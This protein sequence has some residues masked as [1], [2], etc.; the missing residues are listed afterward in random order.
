MSVPL[1]AAVDVHTG[2]AGPATA[3]ERL[4]AASPVSQQLHA[5]A[6]Q[7]L[8]VELVGTV[9]ISSP[10]YVRS[11]QGARVTDVDGH[12]YIDLTMGFGPH[13]LGHRPES[14][15][16][17]LAEQLERGWHFGVHNELQH[18][19]AAL[20]C[21]CVPHLE[22]VVFCNSGTE[23][24][25]YAI[26]AARSLSGRDTIAVFDGC[27][28]GAH[29]YALVTAER[30]SD[31]HAPRARARGAGIPPAATESMFM[32]PYNDVAAYD[33]IRRHRD[34]LAA[35]LVE[36]VQSSNPRTDIGPWLKGLREVCT[37]TGVLLIL[38]EVI[39]GFRLAIGGG[40]Q[41][42]GLEAD[43]AVYGKALGGGMPIGAVAGR[44]E[45]M[46][47]FAGQHPSARPIFFGG[48]F[49]GNPMSMA[50]GIAALSQ[51]RADPTLYTRLNSEGDRLAR[52]VNDFCAS[53]ALPV[54]MMHAGSL[55][56]IRFGTGPIASSR[57][58]STAW[59]KV[60]H[61]F[62]QRLQERGVLIP[63]IHLAFLSTAHTPADVDQVTAAVT[64]VLGELRSD[65]RF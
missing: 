57:D 48:T 22:Q 56:H 54:V 52:A 34:E 27:Y 6:A 46:S 26:R 13:V 36:P 17:A 16:R 19:L 11:G 28:H 21:A 64:G 29:D 45:L 12:E 35:V 65:G 37:E 59:V 40:Q 50:A 44:G 43:L 14:V 23:A 58:I 49:G 31:R 61:E 15:Q 25:M 20:L 32:L 30:D 60:E 24:T 3:V 18:E 10:V 38:D 53:Q 39:T 7:V 8:A 63:G 1:P 41:F 4:R 9:E 2:T 51:M 55:L 62:Y 47:V 33:L 5:A 42:F